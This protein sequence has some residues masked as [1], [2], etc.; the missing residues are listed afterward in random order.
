[1]SCLMWLRAADALRELWSLF[2]WALCGRG[3]NVVAAPLSV[4]V[5]KMGCSGYS[6]SSVT[7]V[8]GGSGV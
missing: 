3:E 8:E 2:C 7:R 6:C 5:D 1:M 4:V